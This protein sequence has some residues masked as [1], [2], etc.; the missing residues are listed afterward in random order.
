AMPQQTYS[1]GVATAYGSSG[2]ARATYTGYSTTY[3][4]AATATAQ[5]Q[6]NANS[7]AMM[8]RLAGS[9]DA[10]LNSTEAI[11][12]RT[13]VAPGELGGGVVKLSPKKLKVGEPLNI[14]INVDGGL[15]S[16]SFLLGR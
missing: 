16:F 3:N 10:G 5:A 9:R 4:P 15:H 1:S 14:S 13:T 7:M 2:F 6:I 12:R 11:L 8:S